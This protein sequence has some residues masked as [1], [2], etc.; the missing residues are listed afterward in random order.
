MRRILCSFCVS[1]SILLI[2]GGCKKSEQNSIPVLSTVEISNLSYTQ[3]ESG[4]TITS[5]GGAD[6]TARG[7][8]WDTLPNP[9][10]QNNRTSDSIGKGSFV[11]KLT[12]LHPNTLYYLRA[13]A[14]NSVGTTYGNEI[15]FSTLD[16]ELPTLTTSTVIDISDTSAIGGGGISYDGGDSIIA[17]GVCWSTSATPTIENF[18]TSDSLGKGSYTSNLTGLKRSMVYYIRAYAT[19]GKGTAYG[20]ERTFF[21]M[22]AKPTVSATLV[23]NIG[24]TLAIAGGTITSDGGA[25]VTARGVCW[26]TAPNPTTGNQMISKGTGAGTFSIQLSDLSVSTVYYM[27]AYATNKSGTAYGPEISFTTAAKDTGHVTYTLAKSANPTAEELNAYA[28]ITK[29]MDSAIWYYNNYTTF[30][31]VLYVSY[32]PSVATADGSN[33]GSIRFGSNTAYMQ[34]ATAMHEIMHTVGVGQN[35]SWSSTLMVGGVY[36]GARANAVLRSITGV[37]TD[38]I[39]GDAMHFWPYGLNYESEYKTTADLINH[40]RI[41]N[42]MKLDGL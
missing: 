1:M 8:C 14:S 3:A 18:K 36:Q 32:V 26:N 20:Q 7:V 5:D 2:L 42:A 12:S 17:R 24:G 10:I 31:K 11:S 38:V 15:S 37:S 22:A 34:K 30:T 27:R 39:H 35:S 33:S 23:S 41:V 9:T 6:I 13:Y 21:T 28:L 25:S 4:G 29:A 16:T 40:C 19:N